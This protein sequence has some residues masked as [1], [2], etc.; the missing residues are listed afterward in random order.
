MSCLRKASPSQISLIPRHLAATGPP[1]LHLTSAP[2][3]VSGLGLNLHFGTFTLPSTSISLVF[4]HP[5]PRR[6]RGGPGS[7]IP[8]P[9]QRWALARGLCRTARTVHTAGA[10]SQQASPRCVT[11]QTARQP[12]RQRRYAVGTRQVP[13]QGNAKVHPRQTDPLCLIN[14]TPHSRCDRPCAGLALSAVPMLQYKEHGY[15]G[16]GDSR[17]PS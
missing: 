10:V 2:L 8:A 9:L 6:L 11:S 5:F 3:S 17:R 15:L 13:G 1:R 14:P 16:T 12:E 7:A 4:P